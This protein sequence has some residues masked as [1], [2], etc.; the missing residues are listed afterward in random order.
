MFFLSLCGNTC[1][2]T[3]I[4]LP[5]DADL[6]SL[7][8]FWGATFP[9]LLGSLGSNVTGLIIIGQVGLCSVLRWYCAIPFVC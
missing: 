2:G 9:Y 6:S 3:S 4:L 7:K 8:F 1:Y 5:D